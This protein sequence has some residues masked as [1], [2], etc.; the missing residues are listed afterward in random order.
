MNV[1]FLITFLMALAVFRYHMTNSDENLYHEKI[2]KHSHCGYWRLPE[3]FT[4]VR[5]ALN[6]QKNRE[7]L[8]LLPLAVSF[9][10]YLQHKSV[11]LGRKLERL[12]GT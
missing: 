5:I 7:K 4:S 11:G 12:V 9:F 3:Y 8:Q 6:H 10:F 1:A 2:K